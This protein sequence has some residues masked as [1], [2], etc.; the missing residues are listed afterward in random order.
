MSLFKG[1]V[2]HRAPLLYYYNSSSNSSSPFP[3]FI[4]TAWLNASQFIS[5]PGPPS[6]IWKLTFLL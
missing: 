1:G 5:I 4:S 3:G 6:G 2:F